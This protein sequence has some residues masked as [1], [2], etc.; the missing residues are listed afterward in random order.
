MRSC[1][2]NNK[3]VACKNTINICIILLEIY[4]DFAADLGEQH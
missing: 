1:D 2:Q 4:C 3:D